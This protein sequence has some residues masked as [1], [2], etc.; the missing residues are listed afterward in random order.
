[1]KNHSTN[2]CSFVIK[3]IVLYYLHNNFGVFACA[4]D[5]QKAF[6][7]IDLLKLFNKLSSTNLPPFITCF[8]FIL[9][10]NLSLHVS[11]N[12]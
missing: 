3:E 7:R 10:S 11:C 12:F 6:D 8:L 9:C 4:L 1:M 2:Q 5:M